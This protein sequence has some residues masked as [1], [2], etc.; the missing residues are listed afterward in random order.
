MEAE[1]VQKKREKVLCCPAGLEPC[2]LVEEVDEDGEPTGR[3]IQQCGKIHYDPYR[4]SVVNGII[5]IRIAPT[6]MTWMPNLRIVSNMPDRSWK[7]SGY[8]NAHTRWELVKG[9]P[10]SM[11][12]FAPADCPSLP[13]IPFYF[14]KYH[15]WDRSC[16]AAVRPSRWK[17]DHS[18][19]A[20]RRCAST[21]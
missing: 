7:I 17:T 12:V 20:V 10:A 6:R 14:D 4:R 19:I 13:I 5:S 9:F 16:E 21:G 3:M 1:E 2:R 18:W 8:K 11:P 15:P